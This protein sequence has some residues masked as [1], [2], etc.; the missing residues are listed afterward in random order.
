MRRSR[1]GSNSGMF[2]SHRCELSGWP[3]RTAIASIRD[4]LVRLLAASRCAR[5]RR[6]PARRG[7]FAGAEALGELQ[8]DLAVGASCR[9]AATCSLSHNVVQQFVAA[10]QRAGQ[11][12]ADP[13]PRLAER[14][15]FLAEEA[16]EGQRV[17]DLAPGCRS[18]MSAISRIASSGTQRSAS[19][20]MCSAGSVT[21]CLLG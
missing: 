14:V 9:R 20:T 19:W 8:R 5:A 13:Q 1:T 18:S 4:Q 7:A 16:V 2:D 6:R 17:V 10:A 12:A 21:A 11:A 3:Q 15:V